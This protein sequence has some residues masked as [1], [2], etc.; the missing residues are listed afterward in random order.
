[1]KTSLLLAV[2]LVAVVVAGCA[3]TKPKPV[4]KPTIAGMP[5]P[6]ITPAVSLAAEVVSVNATGRFAV[7][8]FPGGN[9]PPL[10]QT[11]SLY[12]A[13]LK[14]GMVKIS[15]PQSDNNTVAD[16]ISGE[17]KIGDKVLEQ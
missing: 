1:M 6:I 9:L 11:L 10:Q 15:G 2:S 13:G 8:S 12:R 3:T 7:L 14:V 16:I 5:M 4:A 17:A